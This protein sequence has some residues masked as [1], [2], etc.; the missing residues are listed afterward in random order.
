MIDMKQEK[1][2][3]RNPLKYIPDPLGL[4]R[5]L[6]NSYRADARADATASPRK[7]KKE[8]YRER[9]TRL[10]TEAGQRT[11]EAKENPGTDMSTRL[12]QNLISRWDR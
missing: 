8:S 9:K 3:L 1:N 7:F 12:D 6:K 10:K 4:L 2:P 11:I 5:P